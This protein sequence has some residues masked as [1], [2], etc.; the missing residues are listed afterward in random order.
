MPKKVM[1]A[2]NP[3]FVK[4]V[5]T[6]LSGR[7]A[8][9]AIPLLLTPLIARLFEPLHFGVAALFL[10]VS[11]I[12][13]TVSSFCYDRA[14][15][16]PSEDSRASALAWLSMLLVMLVC[17]FL[18]LCFTG[19][20]LLDFDLPFV[21]QLGI[22]S[23][24]IPLGMLLVG[25]SSILELWLIRFK[26]F[27]SIA[28]ADVCSPL[29]T[30]GSRLTFGALFGSSSWGMIVGC[31]LGQLGKILLLLKAVGH[32][33]WDK[34]GRDQWVKIKDV[35][36]EYKDFP[37]YSTP[38]RFIGSLSKNLPVLMFGIMFSPAIVGFYAMAHRLVRKPVSVAATAFR[39]VYLQKSAE[40]N[41]NGRPLKPSFV[42][43]TAFLAVIGL[44]PFGFLGFYGAE[45]LAWF[46]GER[47]TEAGVY[48]EC[49]APWLYAIWITS[50]SMSLIDVLRKQSLLLKIQL[51]LLFF[52]L[53]V[54]GAAFVFS[55]SAFW[56]L[57][58]F[59]NVSVLI[60]LGIIL[61][62]LGLVELA[63]A[64]QKEG[65]GRQSRHANSLME[66]DK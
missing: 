47:W 66:P 5:C 37:L 64:Q 60:H 30:G 19:M 40:I 54:F 49:L 62:V 41:N 10:S 39:R 38:S 21:D 29:L 59:V 51:V 25:G 52:R 57:S 43:S 36:Y 13:G 7:T 12:A 46:L 8:A 4:S 17:G 58:A 26:N 6:L 20:T 65:P 14:L 44:L 15:L 28:Y 42:K 53:A 22:W 56:T 31:L 63:D 24:L 34:P 1:L 33:R 27:R 9:L 3:N 18:W 11:T 48:V 45:A 61:M 2:S 32:S 50:P 23:W 35:A 16:L 55:K